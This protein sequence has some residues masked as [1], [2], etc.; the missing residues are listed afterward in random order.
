[1][2]VCVCVLIHERHIVMSNLTNSDENKSLFSFLLRFSRASD[3][4]PC[5]PTSS[6]HCGSTCNW[7]SSSIPIGG[8]G[9]GIYIFIYGYIR[10]DMRLSRPV[11]S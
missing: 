3:H 8:L 11:Y 4:G 6:V 2:C 1:M 10:L 9:E 7:C 5:H